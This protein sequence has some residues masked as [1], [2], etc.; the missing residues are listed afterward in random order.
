ME[1]RV[2]Y[3]EKIK[4]QIS[5]EFTV[6]QF[7]QVAIQKNISVFFCSLLVDKQ[8]IYASA[9]PE[10]LRS[11]LNQFSMEPYET[12]DEDSKQKLLKVIEKMKLWTTLKIKEWKEWEANCA[13]RPATDTFSWKQWQPILSPGLGAQVGFSFHIRAPGS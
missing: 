10:S 4:R 3:M 7:N 6:G 9:L 5:K 11:S 2:Y 8:R 13:E 12:A 1:G